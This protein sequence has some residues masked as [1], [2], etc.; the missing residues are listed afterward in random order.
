MR[1]YG[2]GYGRSPGSISRVKPEE[3]VQRTSTDKDGKRNGGPYWELSKS[4][5]AAFYTV[6]L[7]LGSGFPE[8]VY[9]NAMVVALRRLGIRALREVPY[10]VVFYGVVVGLF[11]ADLVVEDKILVETKVARVIVGAHREQMWHYL[12]AAKRPVGLILNFGDRA[13]TARVEVPEFIDPHA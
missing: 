12:H 1:E 4:I 11:R 6:K 7:E 5:I 13:G 3:R 2:A 10:E 8:Y 9:A